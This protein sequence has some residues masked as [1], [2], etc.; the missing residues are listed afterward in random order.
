[1]GAEIIT[2]F[3]EALSSLA[4]GVAST[5][6]ATFDAIMMNSEGGLSNLA[7]YGIVFLA[8]SL[9]IGLVRKFS[10]KAA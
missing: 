7:I 5:A 2:T 1:M 4:S 3:T 9:G 6:V 8:V 10:A